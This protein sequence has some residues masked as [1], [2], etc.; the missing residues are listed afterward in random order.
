MVTDRVNATFR[1]LAD[2]VR[3]RIL[4]LLKERPQPVEEIARHFPVSRPA[5]SKHLRVLREAGLI[6]E[7][8]AGR[9]R[10]YA[11]AAVELA[12]AIRWLSTLAGEGAEI[13]DP[14]GAGD[15]SSKPRRAGAR[16]DGDQERGRESETDSRERAERSESDDHAGRA[17]EG[18][19]RHERDDWRSW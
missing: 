18:A 3:R 8:R 9:Q 15:V 6:E 14:P 4:F 7:E 10:I 2:P 5:V 17:V 12:P 13:G 16:R 11:L 1:G 19:H